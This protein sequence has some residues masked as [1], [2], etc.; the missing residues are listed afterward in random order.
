MAARVRAVVWA[1][2]A[3]AALDEVITYIAQDSHQAA[4]RV[5]DRVHV[6]TAPPDKAGLR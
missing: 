5:L 2:F 4:V 6:I 3:Y 1:E